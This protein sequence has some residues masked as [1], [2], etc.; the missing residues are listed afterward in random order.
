MPTRI[1]CPNRPGPLA[2][3]HAEIQAIL[4]R[5]ETRE[6]FVFF[7]LCA[8]VRADHAVC[9]F[10]HVT[11]TA[12]AGPAPPPSARARVAPERLRRIDTAGRLGALR[13]SLRLPYRCSESRVEPERGRSV[14]VP[15]RWPA[16]NRH[17]R[18]GFCALP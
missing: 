13:P 12:P 2:G 18:S 14:L 3:N 10:T 6:F 17:A 5:V 8:S 11:R 9:G 15:A 4:L 1:R 7:G 16:T